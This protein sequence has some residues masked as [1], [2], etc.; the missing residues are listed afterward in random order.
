M[1]LLDTYHFGR[2]QPL[3]IRLADYGD[4]CAVSASRPT[5]S[6]AYHNSAIEKKLRYQ[7]RHPIYD[8]PSFISRFDPRRM[9]HDLGWMR[10]MVSVKDVG[11]V[12]GKA[13]SRPPRLLFTN[14]V[15]LIFSLYYA[16]IYGEST[17]SR[18]RKTWC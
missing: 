4:L 9:I 14:P 11:E 12:F 5:S 13:F 8:P 10:A 17:Q 16:Y 1:A 18:L 2:R 6:D 7:V 3:S 15:C